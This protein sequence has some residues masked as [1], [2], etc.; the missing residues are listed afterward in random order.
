MLNLSLLKPATTFKLQTDWINDGLSP[1]HWTVN[2]SAV[3]VVGKNSNKSNNQ[4]LVTIDA[5]VTYFTL[6]SAR[7]LPLHKALIVCNIHIDSAI[8]FSPAGY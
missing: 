4:F 8:P 1:A 3:F 5:C 7:S 2:I 6:D